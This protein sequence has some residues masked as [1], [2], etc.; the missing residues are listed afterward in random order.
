MPDPNEL[1]TYGVETIKH[2]HA[3]AAFVKNWWPVLVGVGAFVLTILINV[4]YRIPEMYRRLTDL[5]TRLGK[6]EESTNQCM[7]ADDCRIKQDQC[8]TRV[9]SKIEEVKVVNQETQREVKELRLFVTRVDRQLAAI[10][11]DVNNIK[12]HVN[13]AETKSLVEDIVKQLKPLIR[14]ELKPGE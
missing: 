1:V 8:Q 6:D 2:N 12:S 3:L 14:T 9:C 4:K 5:E 10:T 13:S 11:S 7:L